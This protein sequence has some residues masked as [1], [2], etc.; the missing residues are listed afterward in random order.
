M[1]CPS[2]QFENPP[3]MRFCGRCG[4]PLERPCPR[5]GAAAPA[6]FRFCGQCGG[7]LDD[8]GTIDPPRERPYT[9]AHLAHDVLASPAAVEGER[10]L[11]TVLFC[12]VTGSTELAE[13]L[14]PEAMHALLSRF[15]ELALAE[16]HRYEGTINQ[17]LGD[18]FMALF[19]APVA[20]E[21]HARRAVLAAVGLQARLLGEQEDLVRGHGAGLAVRMGINTGSVVVGGIGD[22]LRMDYTAV[23]DTT[24]TAARLQQAAAPGTVLINEATRRLVKDHV[25]LRRLA[26]LVVKGKSEPLIAHRVV[27]PN[28]KRRAHA[29]AGRPL[30]SFVGRRR[31]LA[32][33][34]ELWRES[35]AGRGQVVGVTGPP[36]VGKTRLVLELRRRLERLGASWLRGACESFGQRVPFLPLEHILR[37][38]LRLEASLP[39]EAVAQRVREAI[40]ATD[41]PVDEA[42]ALL[43][44]LLGGAG[45]GAGERDLRLERR[46]CLEVLQQVLL[47]FSRREPLVLEIEDLHWVDATSEEF[48]DLLV[49]ALPRAPILLL[50]TYRTGYG[51]RW[52]ERSCATQ[53]PLRDFGPDES[54]AVLAGLWGEAEPPREI[55]RQVLDRANGNPFFLEELGRAVRETATAGRQEEVP[56][57]VQGVLT[58]RID[59]LPDDHKRL[60]QAASVLGR[61]FPVAVLAEVWEAQR[62]PGEPLDPL[63]R[64]LRR[65]ELLHEL[66]S[67][68]PPRYA[69]QHALTQE[70]T[71]QGLLSERRRAL[72]AAAARA[73]ES[74]YAGDLT[75]V[76]DQLAHH[77]PRADEPAPAVRYLQ[78]LADRAARRTGFAEAVEAL[79]E[80][81]EVA[82]RLPEETRDR[83]VV[84]LAIESAR[85]LLPL[86]RFPETLELLE[87][88]AGRLARLA[89]PALAGRLR[90]WLAHTHSYLGHQEAATAEAQRAIAA[91]AEAGDPVTE[92]KARYV[93]SRDA[94]WAGLFTQ[95]LEQGKRAVELLR[96]AGETWWEGQAHWVDAFHHF[97]LGRPSEALATMERAERIAA[98]LGDYRLDPSWSTGY[99]LTVLGRWDEGVEHCRRGMERA[100]DPLNSA[101]ALG[102][103]GHAHLA[104]GEPGL[105][106]EALERSVELL[107][108]SGFLQLRGWFLAFLAEAHLARGEREEARRSAHESLAVNRQAGFRLGLGLAHRAL[109]RLATTE[110]RPDEAARQLAEAL[111]LFEGLEAPLERCRVH[112]DLARLAKLLGQQVGALAELDAARR[113][114]LR[115]EP[116][117]VAGR[118][119]LDEVERQVLA[120]DGARAATGGRDASAA[121]A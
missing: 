6:G 4:T 38:A 63:L 14:G 61:D 84:E 26:P 89:D 119:D 82:E 35:A 44:R 25:R 64:D 86:A 96:R 53:V 2:C 30:T 12:D 105:A 39:L 115:A 74:I 100:R 27:G 98:E 92:G 95:G 116:A 46:R 80:A 43:L 33:L 50:L 106:V 67:V 99:F 59:R 109:G 10:K 29:A 73:Y 54:V 108:T 66:P 32:L 41:L 102:F 56:E 65:W 72:H 71:Y 70:V 40:A 45:P 77:F 76:Y 17:F 52:L 55:V 97:V 101:A 23:G 90:F 1:P 21:D 88:Q 3:A 20:H 19:G 110:R 24:N 28:G 11:V 107:A 18:G 31:E 48:L 112:L 83:V 68:R 60:L 15:F 117:T 49:D 78:L 58:A 111:T 79:R 118:A 8:A 62:P 57:T 9:P 7:R 93:L 91:A 69:F 87:R 13:R 81:M 75:A 120:S 42:L 37:D 47:A 22:R 16:V 121:E 34:E 85:W 104:R 114:L 5:C 51:P 94:F 113:A 103:L 36:G